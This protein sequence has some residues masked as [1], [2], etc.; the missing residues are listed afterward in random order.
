MEDNNATQAV[1]LFHQG[2]QHLESAEWVLAEHAFRQCVAQGPGLAEAHANLGY[3]RNLQGDPAEAEACYRSSIELDPGNATVYLNLGALLALQ[4]RLTEAESFYAAA[5]ALEPESSAVWSNLGA[6]NLNL[7][8]EDT[9]EAC[10]RH[11]MALDPA[12]ARARFNLAYLQLRHGKFEE[13]WSL[14]EARDSYQ[15][16]D[17]QLNIPRWTGKPLHGKSLLVGYEAGHGDM[18]QFCR[19]IPWLK[20]QGAGHI[21]LL[22]HPALKSLMQT[23]QAVDTVCSFDEDLPPL[24]H[25]FWLPMLS[26]PFLAQ[27]RVDS[28]PGTLP[29]LQSDAV[30]R[31][32]WEIRLPK[33]PGLRVG[34]AWKGTPRF[35]NDSDRSLPHLQTLQALWEVP[36]LQFVSLQKGEGEAEV[37]SC[38]AMQPLADLGPALQDFADTAAVVDQL[39]LVISVDTAVAHLAGALGKP[40]WLLLPCY[41]PDWRWGTDGS[42]TPW[43]PGVMRLFRQQR[44]GDWGK[45]V[46]EVALALHDHSVKR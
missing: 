14:F 18:I 39:D 45:V 16:L 31:T 24:K 12:N 34:L 9:A 6:L 40:C 10:L 27:T 36:G 46:Q 13:G 26:A 3:V 43:Y 17:Q 32:K 2:E 1:A 21:T 44:E 28:I 35:E 15:S 25:D 41:M 20:A 23:L 5:L 22:C 33:G 11:A 30:L 37:T 38:Y 19:Y 29:Y 7:Q 8:R 4:K 42:Q